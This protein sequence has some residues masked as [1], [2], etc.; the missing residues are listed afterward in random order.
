MLLLIW[1]Y[2]WQMS[3]SV[4]Y[5]KRLISLNQCDLVAGTLEIIQAYLEVVLS[6]GLDS[7]LVV[8]LFQEGE[9]VR[10]RV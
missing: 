3:L 6:S 4:L 7:L 8:E 10:V 9:S 1:A 2:S 5:C